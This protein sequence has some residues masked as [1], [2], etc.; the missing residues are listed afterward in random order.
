MA[1]KKL[2]NKYLLMAGRKDG[3]GIGF[4]ISRYWFVFDLGLWWVAIEF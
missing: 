3:F 4:D 1:Q 2:F